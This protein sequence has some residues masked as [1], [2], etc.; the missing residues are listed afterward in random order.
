MVF[1]AKKLLKKEVGEGVN[2][3]AQRDTCHKDIPVCC[4]NPAMGISPSPG[5]S[6]GSFVDG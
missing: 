2:R 4:W 6:E 1:V 5:V 3:F